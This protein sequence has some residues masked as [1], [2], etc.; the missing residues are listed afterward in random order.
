MMADFELIYVGY[1]TVPDYLRYRQKYPRLVSEKADLKDVQR[2]WALEKAIELAPPGSRVLDLGGSRAELADA[3]SSHAQVTVID[4]YDGSGNGPANVDFYR[5]KFPRV[6]FLAELLTKE[7]RIPKQSAVVTTSVVEHIGK[8]RLVETVEAIHNALEVGGYSIH[9]VDL[10]CRGKNGFMEWQIG[11]NQAWAD[12]HC[13]GV[14]VSQI[15]AA[16]LEDI[17]AF[18]LPLTMYVQ[19]KKD[20][21]YNS[22]PWRNV[23]TLNSVFKKVR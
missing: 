15:A 12:A 11:H 10:T 16:M 2:P 1:S 6:T 18:F 19:W 5:N 13:P 4:P 22:Y 3:L 7:T 17:E 20:K 9:A 21:D 8:D 23:G 14:N